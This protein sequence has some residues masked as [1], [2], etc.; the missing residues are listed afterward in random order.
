MYILT[1]GLW[2]KF[3]DFRLVPVVLY[4]G[5][6]SAG[7]FV[8]AHSKKWLLFYIPL[9]V[10]GI[11]LRFIS[12]GFWLQALSIVLLT[13]SHILLF[14]QIFTHI[15][16]PTT[17]LGDRLLSGVVGYLLLGM[18]WAL[19]LQ[20]P[21]LEAADAIRFTG[22]G[23]SVADYEL[24][25]Y[26]FVTLTTLGFGDITPMTWLAKAISI[27]TSLSGVLYLAI[28]VAAIVASADFRRE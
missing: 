19:Q 22:N 24:L 6:F 26:S 25:Y 15:V 2:E 4:V 12:E 3:F 10:F 5:L 11:A 13:F 8:L 23:G 20:W 16:K 28:F 27:F 7:G 17:L 21:L 9:T 1:A 18:F 14:R